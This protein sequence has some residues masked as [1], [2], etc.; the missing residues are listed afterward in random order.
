MKA[1]P[2]LRI[3]SE[4]RGKGGKPIHQRLADEL[5]AA[6]KK[7]GAS[8]TWRASSSVCSRPLRTSA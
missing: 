1:N 3:V 8:I 6:Y 4:G 2:V 5:L 7:E